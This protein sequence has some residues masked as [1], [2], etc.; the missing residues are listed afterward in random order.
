[1]SRTD[2]RNTPPALSSMTGF[3]R[4]Q[5]AQGPWRWHW[6]VRSVNARGLDMRIRIPE[7]FEPLEQ[8]ARM[9]ANERFS[10]GGMSATLTLDGDPARGGIRVNMDALQQVL[11]AIKMLEGK[12]SANPPTLDGILAL[13]GVVEP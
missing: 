7:G 2:S 5:G 11:G 9:L 3:A 13:R 4:S 12:V 10:R 8:P 1:M 6:E